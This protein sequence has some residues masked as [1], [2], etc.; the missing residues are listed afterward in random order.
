M[1][2]PDDQRAVRFKELLAGVEA[3]VRRALVSAYGPQLGG[4]AA[5]DALAYAWEHL[6][7]SARWTTRRLPVAGG[8]DVGPAGDPAPAAGAAVARPGA[9]P[10]TAPPA[11]LGDPGLQAALSRLTLHQRVAVVLV[12]GFAYRWPKRPGCWA[13]PSPHCEITSTG[14]SP[15]SGTTWTMPMPEKPDRAVEDRWTRWPSAREARPPLTAGDGPPPPGHPRRASAAELVGA[16]GRPWRSAAV[17]GF[18]VIVGDRANR[19]RSH[20]RSPGDGDGRRTTAPATIRRRGTFAAGSAVRGSRDSAAARLGQHGNGAHRLSGREL[21]RAPMGGLAHQPARR[22]GRP[23][24]GGRGVSRWMPWPSTIRS[25]AVARPRAG[26]DRG[27]GLWR[28]GRRGR[29]RSGSWR[30]TGGRGASRGRSRCRALAPCH[31]VSGREV[32]SRSMVGRMRGAHRRPDQRHLRTGRRCGP[33]RCRLVRRRL[34]ARRPRHRRRRRRPLCRRGLHRDGDLPGRPEPEGPHPHPSVLRR[35]HG[36]LGARHTA[37]NRLERR[38]DRALEELGL[39]AGG[40]EPSHG[41]EQSNSSAIFDGA[42]IFIKAVPG[43]QA[44]YLEPVGPDELRFRCG[45]DI[46]T[47]SEWEEKRLDGTRVERFAVD[48]SPA[49]TA[50]AGRPRSGGRCGG[51]RS[52]ARFR[53]YPAPGRA[54]G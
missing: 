40:G 24:P 8:P 51:P 3:P 18:V 54:G 17:A 29:R 37:W 7:G 49:C 21:A 27:R 38:V 31:P 16:A 47:L 26:R 32:G 22:R 50:S 48:S 1:E 12:H 13:A 10:G 11:D 44:G 39:E 15:T 6:D 14:G 30:P 46:Y 2:I 35:D 52:R 33:G 45:D 53:S 25:R 20:R 34:G 9:D 19:Q 43:D 42:E 36:P 28:A 41:G 4:E 23:C 5:A